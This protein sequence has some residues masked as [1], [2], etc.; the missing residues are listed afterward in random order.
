[1]LRSMPTVLRTTSYTS[2]QIAETG[3]RVQ[4]YRSDE[5]ALRSGLGRSAGQVALRASG[6]RKIAMGIPWKGDLQGVHRARC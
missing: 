2:G 1:M 3:G 6:E 5:I 4:S